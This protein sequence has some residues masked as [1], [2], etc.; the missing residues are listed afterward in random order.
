MKAEHKPFTV[1]WIY[2]PVCRTQYDFAGHDESFDDRRIRCNDGCC[3]SYPL[4]AWKVRKV[5]KFISGGRNDQID[6]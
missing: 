5:A 6:G 2:C 1:Y 3:G 4:E